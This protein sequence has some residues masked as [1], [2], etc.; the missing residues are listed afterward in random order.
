MGQQVMPGSC[1]QQERVSLLPQ[2]A[3]QLLVLGQVGHH[4]QLLLAVV[5]ADH[6]PPR[7]CSECRPETLTAEPCK[8]FN[9]LSL[10]L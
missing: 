8:A 5:P 6:H 2:Y 3:A 4:S 9:G 7:L 1:N 10:N